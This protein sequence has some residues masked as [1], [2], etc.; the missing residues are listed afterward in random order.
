MKEHNNF[1]SI[2]KEQKIK[3]NVLTYVCKKKNAERETSSDK[4]D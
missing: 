1:N 4:E 3:R 2:V